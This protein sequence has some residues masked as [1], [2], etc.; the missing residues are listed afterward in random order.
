MHKLHKEKLRLMLTF[1]ATYKGDFG[2]TCINIGPAE[3]IVLS[4]TVC[5]HKKRGNS[6]RL[7]SNIQAKLE[8]GHWVVAGGDNP[9]VPN[10]YR[11]PAVITRRIAATPKL[12]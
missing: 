6:N 5:D 1:C 11:D 9:M 12:S 10:T 8:W 4:I 7:G 2:T 3:V